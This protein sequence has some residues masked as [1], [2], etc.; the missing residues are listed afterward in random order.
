MITPSPAGRRRFHRIRKES[1]AR[2]G[3]VGPWATCARAGVK[4]PREAGRDPGGQLACP[5]RVAVLS[6]WRF[7]SFHVYFISFSSGYYGLHNDSIN[8]DFMRRF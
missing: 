7:S 6:A 3:A 2:G 1:R 5:A 8:T 4:G